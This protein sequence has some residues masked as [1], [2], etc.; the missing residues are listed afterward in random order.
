MIAEEKNKPQ[1]SKEMV[2]RSVN[3]FFKGCEHEIDFLAEKSRHRAEII[4]AWGEVYNNK[5]LNVADRERLS[6]AT[7]IMFSS[8]PS[9]C[10]CS[11]V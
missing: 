5:A 6:S 7:Q 11:V 4:K 8:S 3:Y 9:T 1:F 10:D 2:E